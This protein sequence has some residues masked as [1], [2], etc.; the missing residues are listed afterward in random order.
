MI[1]QLVMIALIIFLQETI[2]KVMRNMLPTKA[3]E[4]MLFYKFIEEMIF[5][6]EYEDSNQEF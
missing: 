4:S 5:M 1:L 3:R 6:E 2:Y